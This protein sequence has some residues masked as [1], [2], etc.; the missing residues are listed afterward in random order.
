M[1]L[2]GRG[3]RQAK[4][5]LKHLSE[6]A[7]ALLTTSAVSRGLFNGEPFSLDVSGGFATPVAAELIA[8]ADLIVAW[9]CSLSMWTTR[10][11]TLIGK[12]AT[13]I[14]VDANPGALGARH[15]ISLGVPSDVV[16]AARA[17]S[18]ELERRGQRA[19][20]YRT[21]DVAAR[22]AA[23]GR[24]RDVP[25][26]PETEDGRIDPRTLTIAL[27]A[28]FSSLGPFNRAFKAETGVTPSEYRRQALGSGEESGID[29]G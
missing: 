16:T 27:D 7:G 15:P 14:Q 4:Q 12:D 20:G 18:A 17:V 6:R 22:L 9:G 25:F 10:Q 29:E 24:W 1:F 19:Q 2:A 11:G 26:E 3:A 28:G 13:V 8:D 21:P 23:E 5:E